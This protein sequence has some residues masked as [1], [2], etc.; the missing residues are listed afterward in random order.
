LPVRSQRVLRVA[1]ALLIVFGLFIMAVAFV[2]D[3][4]GKGSMVI[5]F[6]FVLGGV[7]GPT[8][9]LLTLIFT[10]I[11]IALS[12]LPWLIFRG[13]PSWREY[14][15]SD[16]SFNVDE[17]EEMDYIITLEVPEHVKRRVLIE[18]EGSVLWLKSGADGSFVKRYTMPEGFELGEFEYEY[19][20][21]YLV[22]KLRLKRSL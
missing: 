22:L 8:T 6:P 15:P 7:S 17:S 9:L 20:G 2:Q 1:G 12:F 11:F 10:G 19:E 3:E 18:G 16:F 21:S 13:R 4:I 14:A 5:V